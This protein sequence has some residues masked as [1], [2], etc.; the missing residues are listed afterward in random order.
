M[1]QPYD[2]RQWVL[3]HVEEV[4]CR[5]HP[6]IES[7]EPVFRKLQRTQ[8]ALGYR[9]VKTAELIGTKVESCKGGKAL[10]ISNGC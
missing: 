1:L 8:A 3:V 4:Q 9:T 6:S 5:E 2:C 10:D 7:I